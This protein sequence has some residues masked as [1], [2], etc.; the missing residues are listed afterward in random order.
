MKQPLQR[1]VKE[2]TDRILPQVI[3][4][5]L[6]RQCSPPKMP[7]KLTARHELNVKLHS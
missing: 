7:L 3:T 2:G 5:F 6:I 4:P 1:P